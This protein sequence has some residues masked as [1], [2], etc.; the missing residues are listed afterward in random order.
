VST[1]PVVFEFEGPDSGLAFLTINRPEARN[2][3][4]SDMYRALVEA[5]ER[6]DA[7]PA[8][9]VF[10]LRGAGGQAF[11]SGTDI[12]Q[13]TR[14]R[15]REDA[16]AYERELDAVVDRLERVSK[17][18]LAQVQGVATGGGCAIA[19]ACD[20]RVCT[21]D[22]RFGVPVART[23]GNCLSA[24]NYA[25]L[26]DLLGPART[27]ELMFTGRLIDAAEAHALGLVNRVVAADALEAA[28]REWARTITRN[29]P[30]T[31]RA[32]KEMIRRLQAARRIPQV[33]ADDLIA[34]CYLSEDFKEGVTAFL[35]KRP[36]EF[37]GR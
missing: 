30:L 5:C 2:A 20:L 13:F 34:M 12:A 1:S 35:A 14:F 7:D 21:P 3:M 22:A 17:P 16:L 9:R 11:M 15:T 33:E 10:V 18:T 23:L 29:A 27:K 37:K 36:P 32:T 28:V 24:A 25:R 31:L 4:T 8:I 6:V 26:L 19:L